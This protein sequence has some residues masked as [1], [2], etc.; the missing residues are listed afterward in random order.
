MSDLGDGRHERDLDEVGDALRRNRPE[1]TGLVLDQV[2]RTALSRAQGR[3]RS[4]LGLPQRLLTSLL[5]SGVLLCGGGAVVMAQRGGVGGD[6]SRRQASS[7]QR[8]Y[9]P[10]DQPPNAQGQ[11]EGQ[12]VAGEQTEVGGGGGAGGGDTG[13]VSQGVAG[14]NA[15]VAGGTAG[16]GAGGGDVSPA[17]R[18]DDGSLPFTGE[19]VLVALL[20]GFGLLLSGLLLQRVTRNRRA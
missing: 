8:Q 14:E 6:E 19:D 15:E 9:C 18:V 5:L 7:A 17:T 13:D 20:L 10:N 1:P 3:A 12:G 4:G 16:A 11:C 2:K